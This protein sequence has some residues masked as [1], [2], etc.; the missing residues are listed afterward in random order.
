MINIGSLFATNEGN[1]SDQ[2]ADQLPDGINKHLI[3]TSQ[4][5]LLNTITAT[6]I[7][8]TQAN[9]FSNY[10]PVYFTG[11]VWALA[12][13][14]AVNT[15]GTGI[16]INVTSS[17]FSYVQSGRITATS[18][19]LG[20]AGNW[21]YVSEGTAGL[22]T[23]TP[24]TTYSNP[25]V[26]IYDTNTLI[27]FPYLAFKIIPDMADP[28]SLVKRTTNPATPATGY[29]NIFPKNC[30]GKDI[31]YFQNSAGDIFALQA[32]L[33]E[34]NIWM[35]MTNSGTSLIKMGGDY[36]S[37]GT[38]SHVLDSLGTLWWNQVTAAST[39]ST[40]GLYQP[41]GLGQFTGIKGYRYIARLCF[42][43]ADYSSGIRFMAGFSYATM[44]NVTSSDNYA[45]ERAMFSYSVAR[46]DTNFM[47]STRDAGGTE[48]LVSTGMPF[49]ATHAYD[50]YISTP[51]G[52]AIIYYKIDDITAGTTTTVAGV[53]LNTALHLPSATTIMYGGYMLVTRANTARNIRGRLIYIKSS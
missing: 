22:L 4:Q 52:G 9:A 21:L 3:T 34:G 7:P 17:T 27:I 31:P 5:T 10:Q 15:M 20:S 35:L 13:A 28:L 23:A 14:N 19:G 36:S 50:F 16:V 6:I 40:D 8:V 45:S 42:I 49:V 51:A 32:A 30:G 1:T 46:G 43:D 18:H 25:L 2:T 38:M 29:L 41:T 47:F 26:F 24:P 12:R 39:D 44:G 37:N 48:S 11:T 33:W 53:D